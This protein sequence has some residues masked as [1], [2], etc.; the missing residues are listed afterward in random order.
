MDS[1][2]QQLQEGGDPQPLTFPTSQQPSA[3]PALPGLVGPSIATQAS[4]PQPSAE[5]SRSSLLA[6]LEE[7]LRAPAAAAALAQQPMLQPLVAAP[8]PAAVPSTTATLARAAAHPVAWNGPPQEARGLTWAALA[9]AP[10]VATISD[11]RVQVP[12][13]AAME[14][15]SLYRLCRQWVQNDPDLSLMPEASEGGRAA[16]TPSQL[17]PLPPRSPEEEAALAALPPQEEPLLSTTQEPPTD[18]IIEHHTKHWK[19]VRQHMQRQEAAR[20]QRYVARL[21]TLMAGGGA[22]GLA[23]APAGLADPA[24]AVQQHPGGP[25]LQPAGQ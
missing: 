14:Q 9:P 15:P 1:Q 12:P 23:L 18:L 5:F 8:A 3:T 17:P 13:P 20:Q 11:R 21:Q 2:Q 22:A 16:A 10:T 24:A 25:V 6:S 4:A 7:N 19:A